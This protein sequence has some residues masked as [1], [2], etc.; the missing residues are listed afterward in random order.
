VINND[1]FDVSPADSSSDSEIAV[2]IL[3]VGS[4]DLSSEERINLG[5]SIT[6]RWRKGDRASKKDQE[7]P[8][9]SVPGLTPPTITVAQDRHAT[10]SSSLQRIDQVEKE[11][12]EKR[13]GKNKGKHKQK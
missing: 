11:R 1:Y 6:E 5:R 13:K 4:I 7:F 2:R 10:H 9:N 3:P 12:L 8:E